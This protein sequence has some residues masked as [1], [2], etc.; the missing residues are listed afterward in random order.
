MT[1]Y[2]LLITS[3][4]KKPK[5]QAI[6]AELTGIIDA[7]TQLINTMPALFDVDVAVGQQLDFVGEWIGFSRNIHPAI[8]NS[9]F[10]LDDVNLGLDFGYLAGLYDFGGVT[11][12]DDTTYR[13][14]LY[15]KIALNNWDGSIPKG[16]AEL[17]LAFPTNT[18]VIVDGNDMTM[19][20]G[21]AGLTTPLIRGLLTRGYFDIRPDGVQ[22]T[23]YIAPVPATAPFFALDY[24]NSLLAGLDSGSLETILT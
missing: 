13:Q 5:F 9:F 2:T 11:V 18:I 19:M 1:D 14:C 10:S 17:Q 8:D 15:A 6:V 7:N 16:L 12:L 4:H 3:E 23:A 24:Q 21:I 20:I 22:I